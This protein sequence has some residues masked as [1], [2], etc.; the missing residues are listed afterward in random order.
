MQL[1]IFA[2]TFPGSDPVAVLEKVAA[3]GFGAAA[4]NMSCCGLPA[5]P[6]AIA[7]DTAKAVAAAARVSGV[8]IA[9]LSGTWNMIHPDPAVREAGL[10]RLDVL[11]G[12]AKS[13]GTRLITLCTGTRDADDQWRAHPDNGTPGAWRDLAASMQ[14]ALEIADR[15]DV[16][17]GVEPELANVVDGAAKARRLL[18]EMGSAHLKIVLDPANLFEVD[19]P[20][21]RRLIVAKAIDL[22][23]G[24]I[25][26]AH[27]KDRGADGAFVAAGTG[28]IDFT[29]FFKTLSQAGFDGPVVT[30]GLSAAEAHGVAAFLKRAASEAG[31]A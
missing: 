5:M 17:L 3:A 22:T 23:A 19:T 1:G 24:R 11:A 21:K 29:H 30:H 6:D 27:A 25:A 9:G 10:R 18:D 28:V 13:M 26:M 4:F 14:R 2:K 31:W 15:H 16:D 8:S 20:E 7:D 12:A